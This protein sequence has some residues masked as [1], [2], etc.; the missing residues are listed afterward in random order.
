[1]TDVHTPE[2]VKAQMQADID[3]ANV[4]TGR[5]DATVHDAIN[6]LIAGYGQG[7]G[8]EV[9]ERTAWYRPPDFPDYDSLALPENKSYAFFTYDTQ[10][11]DSDNRFVAIRWAVYANPNGTGKETFVERGHIENGTFVVDEV[12]VAN[13]KSMGEVTAELPTDAG[14]YVSYR[15]HEAVEKDTN[16]KMVV[17][18]INYT[19][20]S[21]VKIPRQMQPCVEIFLWNNGFNTSNITPN[22]TT[23]LYTDFYIVHGTKVNAGTSAYWKN[24][25]GIPSVIVWDNCLMAS[26]GYYPFIATGITCRELHIT[27]CGVQDY[28]M[29]NVFAGANGLC[30]LNMEGTEIVATNMINCF[31]NCSG[32]YSLDLSGWDMSAVTNISNAFK[33]CTSL[34]R[35]ILQNLPALAVSFSDCTLLSVES[36]VGIIA[37]LPAL[38]DGTTLTCTLGTT[39]T[40]KLTDEQIAVATAK[41]WTIA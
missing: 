20:R 37:A 26:F 30:V 7:G 35:L 40:A 13:G 9:P 28:N 8:G 10:A 39:N 5:T 1:M 29:N 6:T 23:T 33:G 22:A 24:T 25:W 19:N 11:G 41:G 4:K 34:V 17:Q 32:L 2:T 36:L 14:R 27:N 12:V 16:D 18:F 31:Q 38:G 3:A 21:G 15:I